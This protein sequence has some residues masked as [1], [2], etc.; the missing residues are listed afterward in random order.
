MTRQ[1]VQQ[2]RNVPLG[3]IHF[4]MDWTWLSAQDDRCHF[5]ELKVTLDV[6]R[7]RWSS[8]Q[9]CPE[10]LS[11][12][13]V[14]CLCALPR[15]LQMDL[16][17]AWTPTAALRFPARVRPTVGARLT[18]LP[19]RDRA[20]GRPASPCLRVFTIASAFWLG[21]AVVMWYLGITRSTAGK[22]LNDFLTAL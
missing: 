11:N 21:P 14:A 16:L 1:T 12:V 3:D 8:T 22:R 17:T 2:A 7:V 6:L 15:P 4:Y 10:I 19:R 18:P 5:N 20:R 13:G 9:R